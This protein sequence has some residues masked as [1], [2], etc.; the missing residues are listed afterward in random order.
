[1]QTQDF[2]N[3]FHVW[4]RRAQHGLCRL[5]VSLAVVLA[6]FAPLTSES[7]TAEAAE[8]Y[9]VIYGAVA[10]GNPGYA[11]W[12]TEAILYASGTYQVDPLL[13]TAVMKCES[14]FRFEAGSSAGAIGLMQLMPGTASMIGVDPYNALENIIG[15]TIYLRNQLSNFAGWGEYAVTDAV[16]AYNAGPQAVRDYG[17]VPP[18]NET[19][20]Y[21]VN[22]ASAYNDLLYALQA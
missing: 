1:M 14:G 13:I 22:V 12:I 4:R 19:Q 15:G 21:V 18:Y 5:L 10:Q 17:G 7:E 16:A 9:D 3:S 6:F 20:N 11:D 8:L 2:G